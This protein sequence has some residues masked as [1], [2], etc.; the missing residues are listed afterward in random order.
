MT[1]ASLPTPA[2]E[3]YVRLTLVRF[4][5]VER[6]PTSMAETF[7]AVGTRS[8]QVKFAVRP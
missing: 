6:P 8:I 5:S 2:P 4:S 1:A 3:D 7:V